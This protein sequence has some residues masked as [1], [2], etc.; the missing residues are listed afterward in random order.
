M[1]NTIINNIFIVYVFVRTGD[2]TSIIRA[3]RFVIQWVLHLQDRLRQKKLS[4]NNIYK[5]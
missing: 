4:E 5:L 2:I 1:L 3:L